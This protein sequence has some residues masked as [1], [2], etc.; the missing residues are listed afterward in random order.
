MRILLIDEDPLLLEAL[1]PALSPRLPLSNITT[2]LGPQDGLHHLEQE[3]F[4]VVITDLLMSGMP[5]DELTSRIKTLT[6]RAPVILI[7]G[8]P[9]IPGEVLPAYLFAVAQA[10]DIAALVQTRVAAADS[11]ESAT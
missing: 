9:E 8:V 4:D 10:F 11:P 7:T 5:R 6:Q 3:R 2:A 1:P